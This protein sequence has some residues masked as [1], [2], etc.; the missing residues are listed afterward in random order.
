[1]RININGVDVNVRD[2]FSQQN[3]ERVEEIRQQ[4]YNVF[5]CNY[6]VIDAINQGS[7]SIH[8]S[9]DGVHLSGLDICNSCL[10]FDDTKYG[11]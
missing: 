10:A 1:M 3:D 8:C 11:E 5:R 4:Y 9:L 6:A 7:A 2:F